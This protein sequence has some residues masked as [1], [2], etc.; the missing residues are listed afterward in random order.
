MATANPRQRRKRRLPSLVAKH[1]SVAMHQQAAVDA[2]AVV[3][4]NTTRTVRATPSTRRLRLQQAVINTEAAEDA[5][6]PGDRQPTS[7][8]NNSARHARPSNGD[9]P[10]RS[11]RPARGD[12]HARRERPLRG[13]RQPGADTP[14][15]AAHARRR[16]QR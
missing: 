14:P 10:V 9:R 1:R 4:R 12:R 15:R 13:D 8:A 5:E 11:D 6:Q 16:R 3:A 7:N 2:I